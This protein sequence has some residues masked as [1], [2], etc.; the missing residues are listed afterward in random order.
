MPSTMVRLLGVSMS[1]AF[2]L[3]S[4]SAATTSS[5][6]L[7]VVAGESPWGAVA[8]AIGGK[9]AWV[10]SLVASPSLDPHTFTATALDAGL[11][12]QASVVIENGLGYDPFVG[13]LLA[14]GATGPRTVVTVAAV[15]RVHGSDANPHLWYWINRVPVVASAIEEAMAAHDPHDASYFAARLAAFNKRV[16]ALV[17]QLNAIKHARRGIAVSQTE[18]VAGYLLREAG[19]RTISPRGFSLAI[20]N[21]TA[22]SFSDQHTLEQQMSAH[23]AVALIYNVQTQS[24]VTRQV[25]LTARRS[26]V[27]VVGFSEVVEPQGA[28]FTSWQARQITSLSHALGLRS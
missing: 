18:R 22:P 10:V 6:R 25:V 21:G 17:V 19:L 4:C 16:H 5:G 23:D 14:T 26:Q 2:L 27:P 7:R 12:N 28:S 24:D 1:C 20:E 3:T 9:R 15:L 13:Q 11:V 8:A